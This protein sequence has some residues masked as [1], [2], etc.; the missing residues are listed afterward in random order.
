[1]GACSRRAVRCA[2]TPTPSAAVGDRVPA[3]RC[4]WV[5][6]AGLLVGCAEDVTAYFE[7]PTETAADDF[8]VTPFP[9]DLWRH[10]DG[11]LDLSRFP[12]N[13]IIAD[14]VRGVAER[15]LDGFGL[16]A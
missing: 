2:R 16:N 1:M 3:M 11:T 5:L 10:E 8:Y 15:E 9:N 14:T 7:I 12:T 4:T 13:S 6:C